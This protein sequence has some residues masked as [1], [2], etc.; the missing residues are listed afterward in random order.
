MLGWQTVLCAV[1]AVAFHLWSRAY[2]HTF[3]ADILPDNEAKT[4]SQA[5]VKK[6]LARA[7]AQSVP[8][9]ESAQSVGC[10]EVTELSE[11]KQVA[12][13]DFGLGQI[14][15]MATFWQ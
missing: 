7:Q 2:R 14:R 9:L 3:Q 11:G 8:C 13:G 12:A 10:K 6:L 5:K 1:Q 15:S 4:A